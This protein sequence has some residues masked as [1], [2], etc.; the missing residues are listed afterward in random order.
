MTGQPD[1]VVA[2]GVGAQRFRRG[3]HALGQRQALTLEEDATEVGQGAVS[4]DERLPVLHRAGRQEAIAQHAGDPGGHRLDTRHFGAG[5]GIVRRVGRFVGVL[6]SRGRL[7]LTLGAQRV[8][9]LVQRSIG[10]GDE[11]QLVIQ[12][13]HELDQVLI[14]APGGLPSRPRGTGTSKSTGPRKAE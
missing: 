12:W 8:D 11:A 4:P 2:R 7:R 9:Q 6:W 3:G 1:L 13:A 14:P 5:G 10:A